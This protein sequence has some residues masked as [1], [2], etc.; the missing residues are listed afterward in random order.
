MK[1]SAEKEL[2]FM[3]RTRFYRKFTDLLP[4]RSAFC[5]TRIFHFTPAGGLARC[6]VFTI[7]VRSATTCQEAP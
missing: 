5:R 3:R 2:L 7:A 1:I 6:R 4:R